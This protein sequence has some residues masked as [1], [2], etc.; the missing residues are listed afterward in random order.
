LGQIVG[1]PL[2]AFAAVTFGYRAAFLIASAMLFAIF[3]V[4]ARFL[5][6]LPPQPREAG[7]RGGLKPAALAGWGVGLMAT[8]HIAF[9]PSV[10]P[11][12]L[13]GLAV[14]GDRA[15]LSAGM[16]V[17]ASGVA[18]SLGAVALS[19]VTVWVSTD[20]LILATGAVSSLSLAGLVWARDPWTFTA[21]RMIETGCVSATIPLVFS[22]FAGK[23]RGRTIGAINSSRFA[24]NGV[25]PLLATAI[26]TRFTPPILYGAIAALTLVA[27][28]I[29]F[30]VASRRGPERLSTF[31]SL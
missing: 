5:V 30:V 25:G 8:V 28:I 7:A 24:G 26:L 1:P 18:A 4:S 9:L 31:E 17:M 27:L 10:L 15:V 2:G 20:R 11:E 29:F 6:P 16:I 19:R 14:R 12:L 23:G 21:L 13:P 22:L 3:L